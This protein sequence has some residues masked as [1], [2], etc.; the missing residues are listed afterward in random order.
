MALIT[1]PNWLQ[2]GTYTAQQDRVNQQAVLNTSGVIGSTSLAVT[3]QASPNMTVNIAGGWGAI[4]ATTANLGVYGIYND[5]TVIQ[6]ISTADATYARIDLIVATINDAQYSGSLNN[7]VFTTVAGTPAA[8]PA[9]PSTPNNSIVLAQIAVAA[10]ATTITTANI[11]DRRAPVQN[12]LTNANFYSSPA[13]Y[14][15]TANTTPQLALAASGSSFALT[16]GSTYEVEG[17]YRVQYSQGSTGSN[18]ILTFTN[19]GTSTG[20]IL[21]QSSYNTSGFNAGVVVAQ[22][23]QSQSPN[24]SVNLT[25][26]LTSTGTTYITASFKGVISCTTAGTFTPKLSFANIGA[27]SAVQAQ[28][29]STLKLTPLANASLTSVGAWS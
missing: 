24:T 23:I 26:T 13:A 15:I 1:P 11:T 10:N 3:A 28:A 12:G 9:V 4:V 8:S 18:A 5:A 7:V 2:A 14:T 16:A 22:L 25:A 20:Q 21:V 19:S 6:S 17:I 27:V 29:F